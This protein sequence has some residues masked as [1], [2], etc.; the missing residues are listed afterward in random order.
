MS[1][2]TASTTKLPRL[3]GLIVIIFGAIFF[4]A[5]AATWTAV[6]VNLKAENITVADDAAAFAGGRVDTPWEAFSQADIIK[7]HALDATGG[8]TYAELDKEDPLR[9]VAMNGSFLRASLFTSVVAFGV[10]LLVMGLGIVLAVTGVAIR[11]LAPA[12]A[13]APNAPTLASSAV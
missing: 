7:H 4:V 11:K 8:K 5:G 6:S 12:D 9:A 1:T 13:A 10:A 3:L 2:P